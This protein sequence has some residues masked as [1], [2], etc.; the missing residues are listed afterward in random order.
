MAEGAIA[1]LTYAAATDWSRFGITVNVI[2]PAVLTPSLK[3]YLDSN[4]EQRKAMEARVPVGHFGA[5]CT[6]LGPVVLFLASEAP[7]YL[8]GHPFFIDGGPGQGP[9]DRCTGPPRGVP[10]QGAVR[11]RVPDGNLDK[12][13]LA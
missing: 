4:P 1:S 8:T 3:A 5:P 10:C 7:G 11:S 13:V 2:F 12:A 6:D 9:A